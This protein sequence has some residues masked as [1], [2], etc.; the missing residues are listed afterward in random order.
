MKRMYSLDLFK[1]VLVYVVAFFHFGTTITP[2]TTVAV[3]IFFV[4]SGFFL[5]KKY[6]S[7]S[8]ADGGE[9]YSPWQYTLDHAKSV[10][11]HYLF[12]L[13][14]FFL[15]TLARSAVY[16]LKAPSW[17]GFSEIAL[18]FYN[19]IPDLLLLQSAYNFHD[20][21]NYPL[22]QLSA[23][24][25]SGY[26]VYALLC[27]NEKLS[28]RILFPAAVLMIQSALYTG[29]DIWGNYGPFYIPLLRAF[30]PLCIGVLA[31]YFTTTDGY[32]ALTTHVI[33]FN[34]AAIYALIG[35]F[36]YKGHANIF[37]VGTVVLLWNFREETSWLNRL[38]NR[39][40]FRHC[41]KLSL[42]VYFNHA[43]IA[44]FLEARVFL[45]MASRGNPCPLWQQNLVYFVMLTLCSMAALWLVE[46]IIK[47]RAKALS[48]S[49]SE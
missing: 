30:S 45:P 19:Q 25:I 46:A 26:F 10:Y 34:L 11:P 43:L 39:K 24:L 41:G 38:F 9:R 15:Y 1:L 3:Q 18:S 13:A 4:I 16:F 12:A 17:E 22:W 48:K 37:L 32:K 49:H 35:I 36:L 14:V 42:A 28:R 40:C 29:V 31:W 5:G 7:R 44:R 23:L 21:L 2:G 6:Y 8:H 33:A 27:W 47:R 20:S